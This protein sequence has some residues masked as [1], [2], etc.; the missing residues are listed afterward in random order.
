VRRER[1][2]AAG[3]S[4]KDE[5]LCDAGFSGAACDACA[6]NTYKTHVESASC[7]ACPGNTSQ[8]LGTQG[9]T[10]LALCQCDAGRR[11]PDGGP[12]EACGANF[13]KPAACTQ[14]H[15]HSVSPVAS[16]VGSQCMCD[17]GY[18]S[19]NNSQCQACREGTFKNNS[20]NQACSAC[21]ANTVTVSP[22]VK[23]DD[24]AAPPGR[25]RHGLLQRRLVVRPGVLG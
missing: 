17:L 25:E 1:T 11:G 24:P 6:H 8:A 15:A 12:C 18:T 22:E 13:F 20:G 23:P 10:A 7:R 9:A 2:L 14:C 4:G 21:P 16:A 5:C 3:R 19:T